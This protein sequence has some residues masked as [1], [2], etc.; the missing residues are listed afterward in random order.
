MWRQRHCRCR[1]ICN[2]TA[3]AREV[4]GGEAVHLPLT[5]CA[6]DVSLAS[7]RRKIQ[8]TGRESCSNPAAA[9]SIS[10]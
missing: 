7:G 10:S 6:N 8:P 3:G 1:H 5:S 2:I 9:R 4:K